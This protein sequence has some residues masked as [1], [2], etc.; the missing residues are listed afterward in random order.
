MDGLIVR[1]TIKR[2]ADLDDCQGRKSSRLVL[3]ENCD[4]LH[5]VNW[6][7]FWVCCI[8]CPLHHCFSL[9]FHLPLFAVIGS[10]HSQWWFVWL[11]VGADCY[12]DI[13]SCEISCGSLQQVQS[14]WASLSKR[15]QSEEEP[16]R[17]VALWDGFAQEEERRCSK[18]VLSMDCFPPCFSNLAEHVGSHPFDVA[19]NRVNSFEST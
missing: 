2:L 5:H 1:A 19:K 3:C 13:L 6:C 17:I 7:M 12:L 8:Y 4:S 15:F 10:K 11:T 9:A 18:I 14:V 16:L